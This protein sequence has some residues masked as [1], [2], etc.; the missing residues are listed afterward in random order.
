MN[1]DPPCRV[2][3]M[4]DAPDLLQQ[5]RDSLALDAGGFEVE[6]AGAG[7]EAL[8]CAAA[9]RAQGRPYTLVFAAPGPSPARHG[10]KTLARLRDEHPTLEVIVCGGCFDSW[11][12]DLALN[13][14]SRDPCLFL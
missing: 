1:D 3:V 13:P 11:E 12:E 5:V 8:V 2:L 6:G 7:E 10:L 9:A 14:A 4:D